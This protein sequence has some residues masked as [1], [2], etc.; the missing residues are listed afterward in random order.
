M[1]A[2]RTSTPSPEPP[3]SPP[4]ASLQREP[5]DSSEA[6]LFDPQKEKR[7]ADDSVFVSPSSTLGHSSPELPGLPSPP[8]ALGH[9]PK[10]PLLDLP[11]AQEDSDQG[12]YTASWGSP[13]GFSSPTNQRQDGGRNSFAL[14][15]E[16]S[17]FESPDPRFNLGNL[18][19]SRLTTLP[20]GLTP[21]RPSTPSPQFYTSD[22][23]AYKPLTADYHRS[24]E[25]AR[26]SKH[27]PQGS[28][29]IWT[30]ESVWKSGDSTEGDPDSRRGSVDRVED[31]PRQSKFGG[32][33][34]KDLL[35]PT[36]QGL[37]N[38]RRH[39]SRQ[40]NLTLKQEDFRALENRSREKS[41]LRTM[42]A[43]SLNASKWGSAAKEKEPEPVKWGTPDEH[44]D[45][46]TYF[47]KPVPAAPTSSVT[48]A[49]DTAAPEPIPTPSS[50]MES[51]PASVLNEKKKVVC[52]GKTCWIRLPPYVPRGEPGT[53]P[54]PLHPDEVS[55]R[56]AEYHKQGY[57]TRG[58]DHAT[59]SSAFDYYQQA[60]SRAIH[61]DPVDI[62]MNRKN[63]SVKIPDRREWEA[64]VNYLTEQKL[65][66]LGVSLG[67][68]EPE[69]A[70]TSRQSSNQYP[71]LPFSP[72]LP[73]S[74]AGSN[75]HMRTGSAMPTSY[76]PGSSNHTSRQSVASPISSIG[77]PRMSGHVSRQSMF[78]SPSG[79]PPPQAPT[80]P[81]FNNW[82]PQQFITQ[83]GSARGGSPALASSRPDLM[84]RQSPG[85]P[86]QFPQG[87]QFPFDQREDLI[88]Q[89]QRQQQLQQQQHQMSQM[90][91]TPFSARP[92]PTLAEVPEAED[93]EEPIQRVTTPTQEHRLDIAVPTPR[94]HRHNISEKLER[95]V[96]S[97][98]YHLEE[99]MK[100]QFDPDDSYTDQ[101][102]GPAEA[103]RPKPTHTKS[104]SRTLG[105]GQDFTAKDKAAMEAAAAEAEA[106]KQKKALSDIVT[107]PSD[108][109]RSEA[110]KT[111]EPPKPAPKEPAIVESVRSMPAS[112]SQFGSP[113]SSTFQPG[114]VAHTSSTSKFNVEAKEFVSSMASSS[115]SPAA[116]TFSPTAF[117]F[118]PGKAQAFSP[119]FSPSASF[120]S[121]QSKHSGSS[122]NVAA[123]AFQ[124]S[125]AA[126]PFQPGASFGSAGPSFGSG[127]AQPIPAF[128]ANVGH[129]TGTPDVPSENKIFSIPSF[130]GIVKPSKKSKAVP[131]VAPS[132]MSDGELDDEEPTEDADGRITQSVDRQKRARRFGDDGDEEPRFAFPSHPFEE[133]VKKPQEVESIEEVNTSAKEEDLLDLEDGEESELPEPSPLPD[134]ESDGNGFGTPMNE[135][136]I[137]NT[138]PLV[139]A[140]EDLPIPALEEAADRIKAIVGKHRST[141]SAT[142]KPFV[143][144]PSSY[145]SLDFSQHA[146]HSSTD[147][148]EGNQDGPLREP[149]T[150][151]PYTNSLTTTFRLSD[152]G[153]Q[154]SQ[155][156]IADMNDEAAG[157]PSFNEIDAVMKHLNDEGSDFGVERDDTPWD[158]SSLG[159]RTV[160]A[161]Q[162]PVLHP[163]AVFRSDAPSPS[164]RRVREDLDRAGSTSS[165]RN[166]FSDDR[167]ILP[168]P[169]HRDF[170]QAKSPIS[171]WDDVVSSTED[172]K[173]HGRSRF[174]DSHVDGLINSVLEARLAPLEKVLN[175][176]QG[177][178]TNIAPKSRSR[179]GRR[180]ASSEVL[181]SDADDEDDDEVDA[182][183]AR[184]PVKDRKMDK[185]RTVILDALATQQPQQPQPRASS[186]S[187]IN[188][189][190]FYQALADVK[191]SASL[192]AANSLQPEDVKA[193]IEKAIVE[194]NTVVTQTRES[195]VIE[196]DNV[197]LANFAKT[198]SEATARFD[199]EI[200]ARR[201]AEEREASTAKM[202]RL[203]E[204]E[205]ELFKANARD[206]SQRIRS[207]E[208]ENRELKERVAAGDESQSQ[209]RAKIVALG[210]E[211]NAFES[212]LDEYRKSSNQWRYEIEQLTREKE[213]L[214]SALDT[215]NYQVDEAIRVRE[216][217]RDKLSR[218][219][220]DMA[221]ASSQ[222]AV[223]KAYWQK[224]DQEH[225]TR[226]EVLTA[227]IGAEARTRER[228]EEEMERLENQ[229]RD[230][231]KLRVAYEAL[232]STNARLE[233]LV[234]TL[235]LESLEHQ[236]TADQYSREFREAREAGRLEVQRTRVAMQADIENANH[237]VN[238]IR[239]DL[240]HENNR[241]R[242]DLENLRMDADTANAK[243]EL[244][245][246]Q[247]ADSR[248]DALRAAEEAKTLALEDLRQRYE[249]R[250]ED[251]HKEHRRA[252]DIAAEDRQRSEELLNGRLGLENTK[253]EILEDKVAH[254][255]EKLEV[256]KAAAQAAVESAKAARSPIAT[257][258]PR[259]SFSTH[260]GLPEKISPQALRESI[261]VLQE[262]LQDRESR[263]ED[264]QTDLDAID[265][266]A[267]QKVKDRDTEITWLRELLGV[268]V[269]DLSD[270]ITALELRNFD[271]GAV[272]NAAIRIRAGLQMEIQERERLAAGGTPNAGAA[273]AIAPALASLQ[274]FASPKAAQLAAAWGNWR[275]G[276]QIAPSGLSNLAQ[277]S[278]GAD[279][280]REQTPSRSNRPSNLQTTSATTAQNFLSGLMTPP[281]SNL[282]RTPSPSTQNTSATAAAEMAMAPLARGRSR[283]TTSES[284]QSRSTISMGGSRS[285][286]L[287][288][289]GGKQRMFSSSTPHAQHPQYQQERE[290]EPREPATPPLMRS[291]EYDNDAGS[292]GV[293][294]Y[295]DEDE[296]EEFSGDLVREDAPMAMGMGL[297][298]ELGKAGGVGGGPDYGG[299]GWGDEEDFDGE[300]VRG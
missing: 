226:Y 102:D 230:G 210:G 215:L 137:P 70:T 50:G 44:E 27:T 183:R 152:E 36:F 177:S 209:M 231:M 75:R 100:R 28:I 189:E 128:G 187:G 11:S 284:G 239:S 274:N 68:D 41:A 153:M 57:D 33:R 48:P 169:T 7:R 55:A 285:P 151:S 253:N 205:L 32:N 293:G 25:P 69:S 116:S 200:A 12:F 296:D 161:S 221:S 208:L 184:S 24:E 82:S 149:A 266:D 67:G 123:P 236:K 234:S 158:Q 219:Q 49:A 144:N 58:F 282:R 94:G 77:N 298:E 256:T 30:S 168:S 106:A 2:F 275:K 261:A 170:E 46:P 300:I 216:G 107:N 79:F 264:L 8:A 164:P 225:Q 112:A 37:R 220:D 212:T 130:S 126:K 211:A 194:N 223:E 63:T 299:E 43:S 90:S 172:D 143:F 98:D 268:R 199:A 269:D 166:P 147:F 191:T 113:A 135:D 78:V 167:A 22:R 118:Q 3:S 279:E 263:I 297:A 104:S 295:D 240:E 51:R 155:S 34:T 76:F 110:G 15:S 247:E 217:M 173:F 1:R 252:S 115:F 72:P 132:Q 120:T 86:F 81:G 145:A 206:E 26:T 196:S 124:P 235:R 23:S 39:R 42:S 180:M 17:E 91:Q 89:L 88:V 154:Q 136:P 186:S 84:G 270:L 31:T 52:K 134:H 193:I 97:A 159:S 286:K 262:Q 174:F 260:Q 150:S 162:N 251:L 156:R 109:A 95:G 117:A 20:S 267:P 9:P 241:I 62:F 80:P 129:V 176:I 13:Y 93:E 259:H 140:S 92:T 83:H 148:D 257:K 87:E 16:D 105:Q 45:P 254:L 138:D 56:F 190:E 125:I 47:E 197:Q 131:I 245:L 243:H 53:A 60:Q 202:L 228:L 278:D 272:R 121:H 198:F 188:A 248:R 224:A 99:D 294:G 265:K 101:F 207:F 281:Q 163:N 287:S 178:L 133:E 85:S 14:S 142:A 233:D 201:E 288:R 218:L 61:P 232:Q 19:P 280:S 141:L 237:Q 71:A 119:M 271:R 213:N 255:E 242:Q 18:I 73:T 35:Q 291:R 204:E 4:P 139:P 21:T 182:H 238:L 160:D 165:A 59:D 29:D 179:M 249:V 244:E 229:E 203:A 10:T 171:E 6:S 122:L 289:S 65:A 250:V 146:R 96:E 175:N 157:Q 214:K 246:E 66:A 181:D 5:G 273:Q 258:A 195:A 185:I 277:S 283:P 64:Y 192:F 38:P 40:E 108:D 114:H 276:S 54:V 227:R 74:S 292:I 127:T 111:P 103:P 290:Q 222:M